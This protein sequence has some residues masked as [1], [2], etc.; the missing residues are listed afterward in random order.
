MLYSLNS[1][2][3]LLANSIMKIQNF[4]ELIVIISIKH[5]FYKQNCSI[6]PVGLYPEY[7]IFLKQSPKCVHCFIGQSYIV[8]VN[9]NCQSNCQMLPKIQMYL[10][11]MPGLLSLY[12]LLILQ[13]HSILVYLHTHSKL[14]I[15]EILY[16]HFQRYPK[17]V[18][19]K[20]TTLFGI[21]C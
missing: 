17:G 10:K 20:N 16:H 5:N 4:V 3:L 14:M 7:Q 15:L 8:T 13:L 18:I 19:A 1:S 21:A 2:F 9:Y 6:D 11:V 12:Y